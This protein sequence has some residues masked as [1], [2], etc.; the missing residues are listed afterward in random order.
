MSP[1]VLSPPPR[2]PLWSDDGPPAALPPDRNGG[3]PPPPDD[4][5]P[6]DRRRRRPPLPVLLVVCSLLGGGTSVAALAATGNLGHDTTKT[7]VV[8]GAASTTSQE[9]A[10]STA[11]D[12]EALYASTSAGVV[13]ITSK[14]VTSNG[15]TPQQSTGTATGTGFEVD[16]QGHI[17]TAAHVVDGASSVT[18]KLADGTTRTATVL[19]KDDATDIAVLKIDPSGLKLSPLKLGSSSSIDVGAAVAAVGDPF[20]YER[21]IS[22][23]IISG[24][25][26][27]IQAPNGFTVAHAL[28][29]DAAINPGNSGGP[30]LDS[31][32]NVIGIADQ[33]ATDGSS[34]QSSGVGF[35]VPIDLVKS[36][37]TTLE[38]GKA[39]EHAYL[40]VSTS[41]ASS[42]T[43]GVTVAG[44]TSGGPAQAAGLQ[45]GDVITK[46]GDATVSDQNGL[47][48]AIAALK[49]GAQVDV[50][51]VRGSST[52]QLHVTLGTQPAQS[53]TGG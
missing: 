53:G 26:R 8:T 44:I 46:L 20:G 42:S 37:L 29:I 2:R 9:S 50:T 36:E 30:I 5:Q 19:G 38:A 41:D 45:A 47:V 39:V 3:G 31:S 14:G 13:D 52:T 32:G 27:T 43:S 6:P 4:P 17:V 24:V 21:S 1:S 51:V 12:A 18:V 35:A 33:I 7:T 34:E 48:A 28:Q 25:D 10:A 22:T 23:G 49:P 16:T 15:G 11:L 40:G